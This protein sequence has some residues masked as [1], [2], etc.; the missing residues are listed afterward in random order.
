M[1]VNFFADVVRPPCECIRCITG[2]AGMCAD[3]PFLAGPGRVPCRFAA[4]APA[5]VALV[6]AL[7]AAASERTWL[8]P[9]L[10]ALRAPTLCSRSRSR[11]S[12]RPRL[13]MTSGDSARTPGVFVSISEC[14]SCSERDGEGRGESGEPAS[15]KKNRPAVVEEGTASA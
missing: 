5:A 8:D 4:P 1:P 13:C 6:V 11:D 2:R 3:L 10:L 15:C 7:G 14:P 9:A 12:S